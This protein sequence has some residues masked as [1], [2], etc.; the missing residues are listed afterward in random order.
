VASII[1]KVVSETSLPASQV[2]HKPAQ[3]EIRIAAS[4][5][6]NARWQCELAVRYAKLSD[7]YRRTNDR[8]N[9][10]ATLSLGQAIMDRPTKLSPG[11]TDWQRDLGWF[12][13]QFAALTYSRWWHA[14]SSAPGGP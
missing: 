5:Q 9:A 10:L 1:C 6:D 14:L 7:V 3:G 2:G 13:S 4:S 11:N 8:D 12:N